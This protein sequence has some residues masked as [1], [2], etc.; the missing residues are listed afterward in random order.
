MIAVVVIIL[1]QGCETRMGY[2]STFDVRY[3]DYSSHR[4]EIATIITYCDVELTGI[5][6]KRRAVDFYRKGSVVDL[7][8]GRYYV[9][10]N[11]NGVRQTLTADFHQET[12]YEVYKR[13]NGDAWEF[14][15]EKAVNKVRLVEKLRFFSIIAYSQDSTRMKLPQN[16]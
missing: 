1:L 10:I 7:L 2:Y 16:I 9:V 13:F 11:N 12:I 15:I 5:N 4:K 3:K 8:P 14:V 6:T